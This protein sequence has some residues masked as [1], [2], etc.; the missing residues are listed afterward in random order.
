MTRTTHPFL[1]NYRARGWTVATIDDIKAPEKH[2]C[3]AGPF[4]SSISSKFFTDSGVPIIRGSNLSLT[5]DHRFLS[6]DFA[7]VSQDTAA[8]FKAHTVIEDDLVFTCWGSVGQ[9]GLIPRGGPFPQYIISNKQLKLRVNREL[10]DP[11]F[12]YYFF[13]SPESIEYVKGRAIGSAVPGINLGILKSLP[14]VLPPLNEQRRIV[15]VLGAY[16]DLIG[17]NRRRIALM[18]EMARSLFEEWF[19]HFRFPDASDGP[20]GDNIGLPHGWHEPTIGETAD[21]SMGGTWGEDCPDAK[22]SVGVWVFRGTDFPSLRSGGPIKVPERFVSQSALDKRAL[23]ERDIVIEG[24][25]GSK[26]QPVGRA[27]YVSQSLLDRF[28]KEVVPASFCK[29]L[30]VGAQQSPEITYWHLDAMYRNGEI[31]RY[32]T[33]STGLRNLQFTVL[34]NQE[35]IVSPNSS[36][37]S[38]FERAV[39]PIMSALGNC[40]LQN[41]RLAASRD[42]LL[43]RLISGQLSL[44]EA[45]RELAQAA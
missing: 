24:S 38:A 34:L 44:A 1:Q 26:D 19:V 45:E 41:S 42:L 40:A 12:A 16:D 18:E 22:S 31:E 20:T 10:V 25:G 13:A 8:R 9:V 23:R 5:L 39:R 28:N 36:V 3:V 43:P 27:L 35:Q 7:F 15:E 37:R 33:Q 2:A 4:G 29:I 17:V 14:I 21:V 11:L 6:E 30:R 32:Q